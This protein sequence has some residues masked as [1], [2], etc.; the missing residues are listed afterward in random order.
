VNP[1][2]FF[3]DLIGLLG[4]DPEAF[5]AS[6][7]Y[8]LANSINTWMKETMDAM[9]QDLSTYILDQV[10]GSVE[11]GMSV[12]NDDTVVKIFTYMLPVGYALLALFFV[13][14]V[15]KKSAYLEVMTLE[16]TLK[17]VLMLCAG[18]VLIDNCKLILSKIYEL[19]TTLSIEISTLG[20]GRLALY[21]P[22]K[23]ILDGTNLPEVSNQVANQEI[24][25]AFW[26]VGFSLLLSAVVSL[27]LV[28]VTIVLVV[29]K[30][31]I[32]IMVCTAPIFFATLAGNVVNSTFKSY[33]K[34]F[35]AVVFQTVLMIICIMLLK[36]DLIEFAS[37]GTQG[38]HVESYQKIVPVLR[39]AIQTV[40]LAGVAVSSKALM[41]KLIGR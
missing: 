30:V 26:S 39:L 1:S 7:L 34:Y 15:L 36:S 29:R 16:N 14:E 21:D 38:V 27:S 18:K 35:T 13:I 4:F 41:L 9:A 3:K 17:P 20:D 33:I 10:R 5:L 32:A 6:I 31:E 40:V 37:L 2:D 12:F 22:A 28:V 23:G 24:M 11:G 25:T 8:Y 19:A